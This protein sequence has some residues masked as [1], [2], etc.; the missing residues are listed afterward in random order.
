[1]ANA[2]FCAAVHRIYRPSVHVLSGASHCNSVAS[3]LGASSATAR[4][5]KPPGKSVVATGGSSLP[6]SACHTAVLVNPVSHHCR[7]RRSVKTG[8]P[9]C[10]DNCWPRR[11]LRPAHNAV[12]KTTT[13]PQYT[14]RPRNRTDAGVQRSRQWPQQKLIRVVSTLAPRA[15]PRG[16]RA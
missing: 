5:S 15:P 11:K 4:R 3:T 13:T 8:T 16:L 10:C 12:A 6:R 14:R 9:N 2:I 1:M 7:Q